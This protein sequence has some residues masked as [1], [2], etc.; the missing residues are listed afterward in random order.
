M[1]L[2]WKLLRTHISVTQFTG[3]F[4]ANLIGL[5]IVLAGIQFREDLR[6]LFTQGD[7]FMKEDYIVASKKVNALRSI[8]GVSGRFSQSEIEELKSQPFIKEVG[9]FEAARFR[10]YGG[11]QMQGTDL[12]CQTYM[13]FEAVPDRFIDIP[14]KEWEFNEDSREIPIIIPRSY[15]NL[16]NFGFAESRAMPKLSEGMIKLLRL[17]I[18]LRGNGKRED[19][20]GRIEGFSN[21]L[22]TILVPSSFMKWANEEFGTK[23]NEEPV[24]IILE[25]DNPSD[26]RVAK[27]LASKNYETEGD[28][29][30]SGKMAHF[31]RIII[32]I[33]LGV[34]VLICILSFFILLLSIYLLLQKN[35]QK[36]R[37]LMLIGYPNRMISFFYVLFAILLNLIAAGISLGLVAYS[38]TFYLGFIEEL[39][40]GITFSGISSTIVFSIILFVI[41]SLIDIIIIM[42]K[43]SDIRK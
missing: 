34:G 14:L 22:N 17:D 4:I 6:P 15:L 35:A 26:E 12:Y 11:L 36:L 3:F 8:A 20:K 43:V 24:R 33:V 29:L 21:R 1:K 28:K 27:Y 38:R 13:F 42:K 37:N 16:Y 30:N 32:G 23:E 5:T 41:I 25:V 31:M 2:L 9:S 39:L 19:F 10:V 18:N 7:S 40:P